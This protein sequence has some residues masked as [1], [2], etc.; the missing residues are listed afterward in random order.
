MYHSLKRATNNFVL[1]ATPTKMTQSRWKSFRKRIMLRKATYVRCSK[2]C[3][4]NPI[5]RKIMQSR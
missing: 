3:A 5:L 4:R 2:L 1:C